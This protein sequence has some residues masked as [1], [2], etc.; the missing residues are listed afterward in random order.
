MIETLPAPL[1]RAVSRHTG[2]V[3]SLEE[4]LS[5]PGEPP[6]FR[7][8]CDVGSGMELLG[9]PLDHLS[10]LGGAGRSR[11][12]AAAAAVGE[13]LERYSATYVPRE[14]IVVASA[15][16]LGDEAVAPERFALFS[17]RQYEQSDF[18]YAPFGERTRVAW[19]Q[20]WTVPDGRPAWLPADL[21]FLGRLPCETRIGYATSSGAACAASVE[22]AVE[23]GLYEVLERDAFLIV[24]SNRLSLPLLDSSGAERLE[25]QHR[26]LLAST[27]LEFAAV[28]LSSFHRLP[29]VLG[30]VRARGARV[31]ALGVGAGTGPDLERA[32][33]KALAEA[34]AARA[35]GAKLALLEPERRYG[36]LGEGVETFEDHIRYYADPCRAEA[37]AFLDAGEQRVPVA[38]V[39]ALEGF[40]ASDRIAALSARVKDAGAGAYAVDVTAPDVAELGLAVAKVLGPE[41][42]ALDVSHSARFL[43]GRRLFTAAAGLGLRD[44]LL[45]EEEVNAEPHPFP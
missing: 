26:G 3:R 21:V 30:V 11:E 39:P 31:G 8:S 45:S 6:L 44:A 32:W 41:L 5:P 19:V 18:P 12:E 7:A 20:G 24:W 14:R 27:A 34:S 38:A 40:T 23:R 15:H 10:G 17:L 36:P 2:I 9:C 28:D 4:C 13:A 25:E 16:E 37:A 43:G 22:E 29:S 33:W 42:C 1:R 35:A